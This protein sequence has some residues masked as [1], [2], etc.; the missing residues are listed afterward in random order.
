MVDV[1]DAPERS[2]YE[3]FEDGEP[4][5]HL[6]YADRDGVRLL[7]HAEVDPS[8]GGRGLGTELTAR[9]LADVRAKGLEPRPVCSFVAAHMAA[10]RA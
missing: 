5:G 9:A 2:R 6:D 10:E 3:L 8:R 4:A 1:H 7:L